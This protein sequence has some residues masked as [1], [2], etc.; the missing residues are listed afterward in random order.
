MYEKGK[1]MLWNSELDRKQQSSYFKSSNVTHILA[2]SAVIVGLI[3]L[4]TN[5]KCVTLTMT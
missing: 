4:K 5:V 3:I 1:G 2:Q